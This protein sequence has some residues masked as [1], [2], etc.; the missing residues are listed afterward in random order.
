MRR[1]PTS[2]LFL[3]VL[4]LGLALAT[5]GI[6]A[7]P[8][9]VPA[10][11]MQKAMSAG[12]VRVIVQLGGIGA[13]PEAALPSAAAVAG[14]RQMIG[15]V[16]SA[17]SRGL[18]PTSHRVT[19]QFRTIPYMALEVGPDGLRTLDSMRGLVTAVHED[20]VFRPMLEQSGPLVQAPQAWA[21]GADGS[22]MVIAVLDTGVDSNHPFLAGKVVDEA[23]FAS[24]IDGPG[25]SGDCPNG[26]DTQLGPGAAA[27]CA[28]T[29]A[30]QGFF[31][32]CSHGTHVAGIAAGNGE[33]LVNVPRSGI[34]RGADIMAVQ[35]FSSE[36]GSPSASESDIIAGLEHVLAKS[37]APTGDG[38]FTVAAV[39]MSLGG[40]NFF[41]TAACDTAAP[42]TKAAIDNLRNAG[43]ATVVAAGN[44]GKNNMISV[45]GCISSAVSVGSTNDS[46]S[47]T[48]PFAV[49]PTDGISSFSNRAPFLSLF[50]PGIWI[51]SSTPLSDPNGDYQTIAGTSMATPHVAG[52]FAVLKQA[53]PGANVSVLLQAL[54]STGKSIVTFPASGNA[55]SVTVK[56]INVFA[57]LESFGPDLTVTAAS[58]VAGAAPGTNVS[59]T[60]TLKNQGGQTA[61]ASTVGFTLVP[62]NGAGTPTGGD[63]PIG[64]SRGVS[65]LGSGASA[66]GSGLVLIPGGTTPGLYR[67]RVIADA[68]NALA[69]PNE[70]N[71]TLLTIGTLNIA[72]PNLTVQSVTFTPAASKANGSVTITHVVKN[73]AAVPGT[74]PPSTSSLFLSR[75][76]NSVVGAIPLTNVSVP[77]ILGGASISVPRLVTI[78]LDTAPDLYF[79]LAQADAP[80]NIVETDDTNN[81]GASRV[82]LIVGPDLSVTAATAPTGAAPGTNLS[83]RYTLKNGGGA[84]ANTFVVGFTLV[85]VNTMGVPTGTPDVVVGPNRSVTTV[86][87]GGTATF[88]DNMFMPTSLS[89]GL[90]KVRVTADALGGVLEADETNNT[91]LTNVVNVVRPDLTVQSVT[92]TPAASK[93]NGSVSITHSVKNLSPAPGTAPASFSSLFLSSVNNSVVGAIPLANVSVAQIL[94]GG[95]AKVVSPVTIP[96]GTA[97]G[98]YY[99][100]AHVD[101]PDNILEANEN[102]NLGASATRI[103]VGPDLVVTA[104]TPSVTLAS[105]GFT[106]PVATT[107]LNRGGQPAGASTVSFFLSTTAT[108]TGGEVPL[109]AN[110]SIASLAPNASSSATTSVVIPH[111][112]TPGSYFILVRADGPGDVA[113]ADETNNVRA[114]VAI[115]V[116]LPN[117]QVLTI[118]PPGV[119]IRGKVESPPMATVV[120]KNIG[121]GPSVPFDVQVFANRDDG[122]PAAQTPGAGDLMFNKSVVGSIAPGRSVSVSGPIVVQEVVNMVVRLAG[123]YFVS[124]LADPGAANVDADPSNN[125]FTLTAKKVAILPDMKKLTTASVI[126]TLTDCEITN[127]NLLGPFHIVNQTLANPSSFSGTT[128]LKDL[129][130]GFH[131]V[132]NVTG[133]VQAVD[134][135]GTP[136]KI[137]SSFTYTATINNAFASNGK[138]NINGA[139]PGLN[140][141]GGS[142]AGQANGGF[143]LFTGTIDVTRGP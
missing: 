132:Y 118:T 67:I 93:A 58:T 49:T 3:T 109:A 39:N 76:N 106:V 139:A 27:P 101:A 66:P 141:T 51:T 105:P 134:M 14:Q 23:C 86:V 75:V 74:A 36:G 13:Q 88:I 70:T 122:S 82:R 108:P 24:G 48:D 136:G 97:P 6:T 124:A 69:E 123:N 140:F 60:Y 129:S 61:G 110:R 38:T 18:R 113:E 55:S 125:Q 47:A 104:A 17:V 68:G 143:C 63:I 103:V 22:G 56:R 121:Q 114:T 62:V 111:G 71:N 135:T 77:Q 100:L 57:A 142:I 127:L 37:Q 102:N 116:Q 90:Y 128:T 19:R 117:L 81:L 21:A 137:L 131:Q 126:V 91:R 98:L 85:S 31:N 34:A 16:Q 95:T 33:P 25:G 96:V 32:E 52:A 84:A 40:D 54:Q 130:V 89:P 53:M 107:V 92:F 65:M 59:V 4:C 73:L 50:A 15:F 112:T 119:A 44:D 120:I 35:V 7:E 87:A 79:V 30:T 8:T 78:P 5:R 115:N 28:F 133:T 43:I 45:P 138:G 12:R 9:V 1:R 26:M 46:G 2:V 94:G 72:R 42:A 10:G 80:G 11:L 41:T 64:P 20:R 83:V 99:A 29:I